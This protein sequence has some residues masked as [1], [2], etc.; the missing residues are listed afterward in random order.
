MRRL[1]C[2][3]CNRIVPIETHEY[4]DRVEYVCPICGFK[5]YIYHK[6]VKQILI[7]EV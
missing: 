7:K 4:Y 2:P 5:I 1:L 6:A 3:K